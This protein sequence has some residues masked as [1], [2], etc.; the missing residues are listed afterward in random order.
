MSYTA[1]IH[2][3]SIARARTVLANTLPTAKRAASREFGSEQ[4]DYEIVIYDDAADQIVARR[5][6]G[7]RMW[8]NA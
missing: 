6:A 3:H 5:R 8:I 2:H 7:D 1:T 4:K